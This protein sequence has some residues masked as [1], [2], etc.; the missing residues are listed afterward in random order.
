MKNISRNIIYSLAFAVVVYVFIGLWGSS[1]GLAQAFSNFSWGYLPLL[2]FIA[3]SNYL[4]RFIKWQYYLKI[5]KINIPAIDSFIIFFSGF[6]LTITPGK[7]GEVIKSYFLKKGFD[8]PISRTAPI[9]F[10]DRLT[11]LMAFL[12]ISAVGAYGFSYG[13]NVIWII[14]FIIMIIISVILIRPIGLAFFQLLTRIKFVSKHASRIMDIYE[15]SYSLILPKRIVFPL[16][17]SIIAWSLEALDFY[18]ILVLMN[19]NIDAFASFFV[20]CFSTIIGAVMMMPGG[21]GVTDGSIAGLL[22]FLSIDM[23]SA[24]FA[25]MLI[26]A[27]T[28]WFAVIIGVVFLLIAENKFKIRD[29]KLTKGKIR[30]LFHVHT[31]ISRDG[32]LDFDTIINYCRKNQVDVV[33]ITDHNEI[34]G[35]IELKKLSRNK[36][37]VIIGEEI[38][39]PDGEIIGLFLKKKINKNVSL[40][41]ALRDIRKQGGLVCLPHPGDFVRKSA[42]NKELSQKIIQNVDIVEVF[43]SRNLFKSTDKFANNLAEKYNKAKIAAADA[44]LSVELF[45]TVNIIDDFSNQEEFLSSLAFTD[46]TQRKSNVFIQIYCILLKRLKRSK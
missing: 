17:V 39:T 30:L 45:G 2:L 32:H 35:A 23:G 34:S 42:I 24:A 36:P 18:F 38:K 10:A 19:L 41:S 11:D 7:M 28:L 33:A 46:F 43:N 9:V 4:V 15:T 12:L 3:L 31:K 13:K 14:F 8:I 29:L 20:Y 37:R 27:V 21:L 5:L 26:R 6:A 16:L 1:G 25:T 22:K 44:H 40:N